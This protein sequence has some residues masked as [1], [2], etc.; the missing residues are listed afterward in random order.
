M[1]TPKELALERGWPGRIDGDR[2]VQL[3]AQT[4]QSFFTGGGQAREH[5]EYALADVDLRPPVLYPPSVRDFMAFEAHV[6]TTRA[7]RGLPVPPEWYELP[8]FYFSN[9][10]AIY[11]PGDDVPYPEGSEALDY[12][13]EIAA[14]IGAAGAVGGFTVMNDW[15]ARDLQLKEMKVGLGPAK[16]KDFATSLGPILITP[17]EFDG[18]SA[19]MIARV[20]GEERS[21]GQ[22]ADMQYSW[23]AI[24]AQAARNTKLFA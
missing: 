6:E 14:V 18:S 21:R 22:L 4:L 12:E 23:D 7:N 16:G 10:A 5:A 8:V 9:P 19:T 13:L 20:N 3:A 15:S 24:V 1:F 11:G 2:V 17:D